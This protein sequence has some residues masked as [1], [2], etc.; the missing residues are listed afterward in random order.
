MN[1]ITFRSSI[2]SVDYLV[3]VVSSSVT[4]IMANAYDCLL[5]GSYSGVLANA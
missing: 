5:Q 1:E 3:S 2:P 4:I